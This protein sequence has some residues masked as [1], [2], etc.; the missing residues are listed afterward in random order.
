MLLYF[1]AGAFFTTAHWQRALNPGPFFW[2]GAIA[3]VIIT[4]FRYW[5]GGDWP[6]YE[7][8]FSFAG[9]ADLSQVLFMGDPGYQVLNWVVRRLGLEIWAVNLVCGAVYA[10]G[11]FN[12]ARLQPNPWLAIAVAIPYLIIVVGMGY[13]RQSVALGFVMIG[14]AALMR[15]STAI[16]Y[17]VYVILATLFHR[18]AI[19][20]TLVLAAGHR[21]RFIN[22]LIGASSAYALYDLVVSSAI[23]TLSK[24]YIEAEYDAQGATVRVFMNFL[25]AALFLL[26]PTRFGFD[27]REFGIV[28][29]M[30]I[31]G[32][33][34]PILLFIVP[35]SAA[36]DRL[37]LYI[38]PLQMIILSRVPGVLTKE[39]FGKAII[40]AYAV[41]VQFVW[42]NFA[43]H[44]RDWVPYRFWFVDT[45][46]RGWVDPGR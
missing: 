41:A 26:A 9:Y 27:E 5:I 25:P 2:F 31:I 21:T 23:P 13:T 36:V 28:R 16:R 40:L 34:F 46:G 22:L 20:M 18:S 35:S 39:D 33:V 44:A 12:L 17:V 15:G 30:A 3:I 11:L 37:A 24:N 8:M 38:S 6:Q 7:R 43:Q 32:L 19:V 1:A 42:L 29:I 45:Y 10:I 14:L 4:G